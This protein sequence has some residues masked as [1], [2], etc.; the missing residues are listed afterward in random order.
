MLDATMLGPRASADP[1][2][3][4]RQQLADETPSLGATIESL[5]AVNKIDLLPADRREFT[6]PPVSS[7]QPPAFLPASALTGEGLDAVLAAISRRL[8]PQPPAPGQPV[9]FT[10]RQIDLLAD[11]LAAL[12][13]S[14][15]DAARQL[16]RL[17][18]GD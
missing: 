13:L 8:V 5:V 2:A 7:L 9:A 16:D 17:L 6:S 10:R 15:A 14:L 18:S 4:A 3:V 1:V 12:D 11:A